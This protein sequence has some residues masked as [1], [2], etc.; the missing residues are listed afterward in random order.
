MS[1]FRTISIGSAMA[2]MALLLLVFFMASTS[3]EPP[4][5]VSLELPR[6]RTQGAEQESIYITISREGDLYI[7]GR[8]TSEEDL[9]DSLAMRQSEKDRV[10]SITA[11]KNLNYEIIAGVL[12]ILRSQDFLNIVFMSES[13]KET[14]DRK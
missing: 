8:K 9:H 12:S 5:G 11:D 3:T 7:D 13:R 1:R 4:S 10:V 6:A 14:V 2:D